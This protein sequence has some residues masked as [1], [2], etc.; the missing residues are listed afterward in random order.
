[1]LY[2]GGVAIA[3]IVSLS[4]LRGEELGLLGHLWLEFEILPEVLLL[5]R[6]LHMLV[7]FVLSDL[8]LAVRVQLSV[9]LGDVLDL[10]GLEHKAELG[11]SAQVFG[12]N[13]T[14]G[15]LGV[16]DVL[17]VEILDGS[18]EIFAVA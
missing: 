15:S 9:V 2:R 13:T 18:Q 1:M 12:I 17:V 10:R 6:P 4:L 7:L 11:L 16:H 5:N 8:V 14:A 3:G